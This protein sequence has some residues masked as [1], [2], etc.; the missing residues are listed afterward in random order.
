MF[1]FSGQKPEQSPDAHVLA[2]FGARMQPQLRA[3]R[4]GTALTIGLCPPVITGG[5]GLSARI[6]ARSALGIITIRHLRN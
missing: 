3:V 4:D 1:V 5:G 6:P 2:L